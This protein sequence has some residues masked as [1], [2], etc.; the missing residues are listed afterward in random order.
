M[1]WYT[2][3]YNRDTSTSRTGTIL[4]RGFWLH[5]TPRLMILC[6]LLGHKPVVDG[7]TGLHEGHPGSRWVC[8][9]RCGVRPQPQGNLDPERWDIGDAY[10][11]PWAAALPSEQPARR[12]AMR[13]FKDGG[14]YPPGPWPDKPVGVIGGQLVL[15]RSFGG[16]GAQIKVGHGGS[17]H[18]LAANLR[19]HHLASLY[20]HTEQHGTWLQRRLN[21][22]GYSS[23][24]IEILFGHN[25]LRWRLWAKRDEWSTS[26]PRWQDGSIC[27][28]PR[29]WLL[30]PVRN[31][32]EHIGVPE[33]V[34]VRMP[35]GDDHEVTLQLQRCATGRARGRKT[36]SWVVDW[37]CAQGIPYRRD[38]SWKGNRIH[39][40]NVDVSDQSVEEGTWPLEAAV[41]IA[42]Q[43]TRDRTRSDY[44]PVDAVG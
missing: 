44:R 6:R 4:N 13:Q 38:D 7:T 42:A 1:R 15:G 9:H 2:V 5:D 31:R 39:G 19:L 17:E 40:S 20:L 18:T 41:A 24:V 14:A 26:T 25:G 16:V 32:F 30:G 43:M 35:H 27:L 11:G 34:V 12:E 29:E 33:T 8:C 10:T 28:D 21:P 37:D 23:R 36:Y 3:D 22:V